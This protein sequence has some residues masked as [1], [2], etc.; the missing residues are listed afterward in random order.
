[1]KLISYDVVAD[2]D[3]PVAQAVADSNNPAIA[4]I[5]DVETYNLDGDPVI[6]ITN[7]FVT[8]MSELSVLSLIHI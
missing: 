6:E 2:P 1:M 3:T 8:E 4:E 7:L 5:F